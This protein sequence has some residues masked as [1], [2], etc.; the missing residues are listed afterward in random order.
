MRK[1]HC[2]VWVNCE[3]ARCTHRAPNAIVP[4]IIGWGRDASSD[5]LRPHSRRKGEVHHVDLISSTGIRI[6]RDRCR[7]MTRVLPITSSVAA[8]ATNLAVT[9]RAGPVVTRPEGVDGGGAPRGPM[10]RSL[11]I[12]E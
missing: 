7:H 9:H 2:W 12:K 10:M 3:N 5:V 1:H 8:F 6:A 4:L 11:R